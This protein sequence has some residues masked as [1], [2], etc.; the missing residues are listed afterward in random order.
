ML[1]TK[2]TAI[3][4]DPS[5]SGSPRDE[6]TMR[7]P[8]SRRRDERKDQRERADEDGAA[9]EEKKQEEIEDDDDGEMEYGGAAPLKLPAPGGH[10][11]RQRA[12]VDYTA[13]QVMW[14]ADALPRGR[15]GGARGRRPRGRPPGKRRKI[16]VNSEDSD[17]GAFARH[18]TAAAG[19][20]DSADD[21]MDFDSED[22]G[23]QRAATEG[24]RR[25]SRTAG[26]SVDYTTRTIDDAIRKASEEIQAAP[27]DKRRAAKDRAAKAQRMDDEEEDAR[28]GRGESDDDGDGEVAEFVG[29]EDDDMERSNEDADARSDSRRAPQSL[30]DG[31]EDGVAALKS[32]PEREHWRREAAKYQYEVT[33]ILGVRRVS[34]GPSPSPPPSS[35]SSSSPALTERT[36]YLVK[37]KDRGYKHCSWLD[38]RVL[39]A[40]EKPGIKS[41][42]TRFHKK[43]PDAL[44]S[45][46]SSQVVEDADDGSLVQLED[47]QHFNPDYLLVHRIISRKGDSYLVKWKGLGYEEATWESAA[48]I[49]NDAEIA[50]Y[51][52]YSEPPPARGTEDEE[53]LWK[54]NDR[55][56]SIA[57]VRAL[58]QQLPFKGGRQLRD[59]QVEGVTWMVYNHLHKRPSLLADEMVKQTHTVA[60]ACSA[61]ALVC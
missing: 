6:W 32:D 34:D 2:E 23:R 11:L 12:P 41:G 5:P 13:T 4:L 38:L 54:R 20:D 8:S 22:G 3:D 55:T 26:K 50:R 14:D 10:S 27:R 37:W 47:G 1:N 61:R 28:D 40:M 49:D 45:S 60:V 16:D 21:A 15:G 44:Q 42:L 19:R 31:E 7:R 59:Y 56:R 51:F 39:Q 43:F 53:A 25:S 48:D 58:V 9:R 17:D 33:R 57:G 18:T 52:R 24:S 35:S 46:S 29:N 30:T 36:E